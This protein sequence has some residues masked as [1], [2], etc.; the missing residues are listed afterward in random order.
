MNK[1][2]ATFYAF[3]VPGVIAVTGGAAGMNMMDT[4]ISQHDF[5]MTLIAGGL[6]LGFAGVTG[7]E[8]LRKNRLASDFDQTLENYG[9]P[10]HTNLPDLIEHA[11]KIAIENHI[12]TNKE[13][14]Q[15][16]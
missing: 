1:L 14:P 15:P 13:H 12:C 8:I 9:L 2:S 7:F 5:K 16:E 4:G 11:K 10:H 6:S 3:G